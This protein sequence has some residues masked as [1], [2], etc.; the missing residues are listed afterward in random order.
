VLMILWELDT[1]SFFESEFGERSAEDV[2][3]I[4]AGKK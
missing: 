2:L 3:A 1:L 4:I